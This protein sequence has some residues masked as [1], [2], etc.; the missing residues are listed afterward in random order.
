MRILYYDCFSG[1]SGDMNLGAMLDLGVDK[2]YLIKEL[3]KLNL[4]GEYEIKVTKDSR[5]GINGTKVD[6]VLLN[7]IHEHHHEQ[8]CSNEHEHSHENE[9]HHHHEHSHEH[10]HHECENHHDHS[11]HHDHRNLKAIQEIISSSSL[12]EKVKELSLNIFMKV[13]EAEAKVHG[14]PL[15]EVHFH[16]VGAIDSIVDIVGAA[17]CLDY[18]KV[19]KI[20]ASSVE[21]G[22]GFVKCAHGLIPVPAPATVEILKG[23]AVKT[24]AVPFETTTPTGA[25]ILA[26]AVE[27]FTDL[28]NFKIDKIGYGIGGRDT[29]I[30]NV[31]RVYLGDKT[32]EL[33]NNLNDMDEVFIL[34]CNIDDMNPEIF[35][36]VMERLFGEGAL[37]V[38]RIPVL[39]K[40]DRMGFMLN[41]I[42]KEKDL[43]AIKEIIFKETTTIGVRQVKVEREK[44][45][46][47]FEIVETEYGK[48]NVKRS[49]YEGK[50]IK[51]KPEYEDCKRLAAENNLPI[52]KIYNIVNKI[53][54]DK[55]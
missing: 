17:I 11:H 12:S 28:K 46:R 3:E 41:V 19:D 4:S 32:S 27:D 29:E 5:K 43:K 22:G 30:P 25:A 20:L 36:Y 18:L 37:D 49:Y 39:M 16:E 52:T 34:S 31:L 13:A 24:G 7:E 48:I 50:I 14:K 10:E 2:D 15:Y 53:M 51:W 38:Y 21:L 44:L 8:P 6:V 45:K 55:I 42:S 23:V 54:E 47:N 33:Q 40:K 35:S 1:I 9:H 26:A